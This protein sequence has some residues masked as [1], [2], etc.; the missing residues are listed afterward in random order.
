MARVSQR[1]SQPLSLFRTTKT[2]PPQLVEVVGDE[3]GGGCENRTHDRSLQAQAWGL[4]TARNGQAPSLPTLQVPEHGYD[5]VYSM[6]K[7][8]AYQWL[9]GHRHRADI[10]SW[11]FYATAVVAATA[12]ILPRSYTAGSCARARFEMAGPSR[13]FPNLSKREPWHGQSQVCSE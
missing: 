2:N 8:D 4:A 11:V 10:G 3:I 12:L 9:D 7:T 13:T 6:S 1:V 5:R